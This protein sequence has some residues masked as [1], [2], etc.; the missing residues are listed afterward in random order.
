MEED[1]NVTQPGA[2]LSGMDDMSNTVSLHHAAGPPVADVSP[3]PHPPQQRNCSYRLLGL[4]ILV[5]V[6]TAALT[7]WMR[8]RG[9]RAGEMGWPHGVKWVCGERQT[10]WARRRPHLPVRP[11]WSAFLPCPVKE[12]E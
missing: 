6:L 4:G 2:Q 3:T 10:L 9:S 1:D 8:A 12:I 5:V 7:G 11:C